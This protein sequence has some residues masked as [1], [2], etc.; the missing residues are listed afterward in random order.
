MSGQ[1]SPKAVV[2]IPPTAFTVER[3]FPIRNLVGDARATGSTEVLP[4]CAETKDAQELTSRDTSHTTP[5]GGSEHSNESTHLPP[6]YP[7]VPPVETIRKLNVAEADDG[8]SNGRRTTERT[9]LIPTTDGKPDVLLGIVSDRAA[10][11]F[12]RCEDEPIHIPGAIQQYGV[13]I[14]LKFNDYEGNDLEVRIASENSRMLFGYGPEQL[15][16]LKSFIDIFESQTKEE[17][18]SRIRSAIAQRTDD[19][20]QDTPEDTQLD[21]FPATVILPSGAES[22]LWCALH[23]A[24]KSRDLVILEFEPYTEIFSL[25]EVDYQ[26]TLP[27]TP[28]HT[29]GIE[30]SHE[31]QQ[32]SHTAKSL[33]LRVMAISR[34]RKQYGVSS[35]DIFN[36]MTQAQQQLASAKSVQ[37]VLDTVVGIVAELT[38]FHRVMLY[39]FDSRDNG[40]VEAELVNPQA[41]GDLFRGLHFPASDIP[42]QARELY[43]VN[44]I[45]ILYDRDAETARLVCR[46]LTDFEVPLD[47]THSYLRAMSPIHL[48][49]LGNMG[50]RSSMS[51]S[52]VINS[53]LWGLVACHGYG[54]LGIR[55]TL[56][57][58]ELCRNI[59][60]CAATNIERLLM[61]QQI[62]S[63][64]PPTTSPRTKH[65]AGIIAASS[66]DLLRGFGADFGLLSIQDEARAIGKLDPYREALAVLAYVQ[67]RKFTTIQ[68]CRNINDEFPDINYPPGI[69]VLSG[70]LV[71][72]L[73]VTGNDFLVFFRRGE[74]KEVRWAGNP[75]EKINQAGSE[76]LEPRTSFK[77]WTETVRGMSKEWTE[78]QL[79]TASVLSLLYGRFIEIWRQKESSG[80][81]NKMTR[82]LI[83]NA[84]HEVRTPLNAIVN[85]LEMALE[86]K[87]D[88]NTREILGK[89]STASRSLVYVINDLLALTK[90]EQVV[91]GFGEEVFDLTETILDALNSFKYEAV[92]KGLDLTVSTH[93]GLPAMVKGDPARLRQVLLNVTSNAFQH[94][95]DGGIKVD[96]RALRTRGNTSIISITVQDMGIGM[97]ESQLDN[98]FQEFEQVN[99]EEPTTD[100]STPQSSA[101]EG[102][103]L[104]VGLAVVARYVKNMKGQIR[105]QSELG[106]GTIFGIELP[107]EHAPAAP[108]LPQLSPPTSDATPTPKTVSFA[109]DTTVGTIQITGQ[110]KS[111]HIGPTMLQGGITLPSPD[112]QQS[113]NTT[114]GD[115]PSGTMSSESSMDLSSNFPFPQMDGDAPAF[116]LSVL[117]AED[118][119]VNARVLTRRLQK[120]GHEVEL[121]LDG[122]QCHDHFAATP[123]TIDVIL[124]DLQMPLV[125]GASST[126]MIRKY[127]T[128]L[129]EE[130]RRSRP[131]V[132]II[133]VSASL[134]EDKRYDYVQSGFDAWLLKPIDVQRLSLLLK[135]V[136]TPE[137]RRDAL[138]TPG[139]WERGGWFLA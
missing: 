38:G 89:A 29:V 77:R 19:T 76:Y 122:Q 54:E 55:V 1:E 57:I 58:R 63:R 53:D 17:L 10:P 23:I 120:L 124:M 125:D 126:K 71:V 66:A 34:R 132:P 116:R 87:I 18:P 27:A 129:V 127:E 82:L 78:D 43:K 83:Q 112:L 2:F 111:M 99:D 11:T 80:R 130:L 67:M 79:E 14:A 100:A 68:A 131:R 119:P 114:S 121:A 133:A 33:P 47:L 15:F 13:L 107:F 36:A 134:T 48:K 51:V 45:R 92:R 46:E 139:Y 136:K 84:A 12:Q 96:I 20:P 138:Y 41:S 61:M 40:C 86:N 123:H 95:V 65:P 101:D 50:V 42:K 22:E 94:S 16:Q 115:E 9:R 108:S 91:T 44:R 26:K 60:D 4:P 105:V 30:V 135:G 70:L 118:N 90:I 109:S 75:Y 52:I 59:G 32:K 5:I 74:L 39:R 128:E 56:P 81:S 73:S 106:K 102:S 113:E 62:V 49:Y 98:I 6:P 88:D 3:V 25:T 110:Y 103:S 28:V 93:Q 137:L 64:K 35:M 7:D 117:I 72:P 8:S 69:H 21:V 31:E 37:Q 85:Y 97:S 104:G 24:N